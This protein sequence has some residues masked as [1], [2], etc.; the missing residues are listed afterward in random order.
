MD[1]TSSRRRGCGSCFRFCR[2]TSRT[3][4]GTLLSDCVVVVVYSS[5]CLVGGP[6]ACQCCSR[7]SVSVFHWGFVEGGG[8]HGRFSSRSRLMVLGMWVLMWLHV[9]LLL[10]LLLL[11]SRCLLQH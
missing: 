11:L 7:C 10:L 5:R 3:F 6:V 1:C 9:L 4:V 2:H 8:V